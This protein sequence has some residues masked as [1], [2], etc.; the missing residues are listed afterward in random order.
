MAIDSPATPSSVCI[1]P[2][3]RPKTTSFSAKSLKGFLSRKEFLQMNQR[4]F[5]LLLFIILMGVYL[6]YRYLNHFFCRKS[7][8][9]QFVTDNQTREDEERRRMENIIRTNLQQDRVDRTTLQGDV[10]RSIERIQQI[11]A[12]IEEMRAMLNEDIESPESE[13]TDAAPNRAP[14]LNEAIVPLQCI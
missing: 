11:D 3:P 2:H 6:L 10:A 5:L 14:E 1:S 7:A 4:H 8:L 9:E 12:N 13:N